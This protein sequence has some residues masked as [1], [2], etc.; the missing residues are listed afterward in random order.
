MIPPASTFII[1]SMTKKKY[2]FKAFFK[3]NEQQFKSTFKLLES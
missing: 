1:G 3:L 2:S